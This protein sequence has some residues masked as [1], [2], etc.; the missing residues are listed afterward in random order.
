MFPSNICKKNL[1]NWGIAF[2]HLKQDGVAL[3]NDDGTVVVGEDIVNGKLTLLCSRMYLF[4]CRKSLNFLST[5][6]VFVCYDRRLC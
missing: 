2:Q 4:I 1:K 6:K 3:Y 5:P